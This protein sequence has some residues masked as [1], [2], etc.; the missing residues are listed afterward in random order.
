MTQER[1]TE[2]DINREG[3]WRGGEGENEVPVN[4]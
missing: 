2:R 4:E 3:G 1:W